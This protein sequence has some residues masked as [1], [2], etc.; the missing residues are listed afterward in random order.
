[1]S[2]TSVQLKFAGQTGKD[3]QNLG[4]RD[5]VQK[6]L[7]QTDNPRDGSALV[8]HTRPI[9]QY[10][11]FYSTGSE[12]DSFAFLRDREAEPV[13]DETST[14]WIVTCNFST[15]RDGG[16]NTEPIV[17][18]SP[19]D[20]A[21]A[22][23][24]EHHE[25]KEVCYFAYAKAVFAGSQFPGPP[26][27]GRDGVFAIVNT[28]GDFYDPPAEREI[29]RLILKITV[30]QADF[31]ALLAA[32][33]ANA[34]NSDRWYGFPPNT[35]LF[36]PPKAQFNA[37]KGFSYWKVSYEFHFN[38]RGWFKYYW[39]AG[40]REYIRAADAKNDPKLKAGYNHLKN[41]DGTFV[42]EPILL[43]GSGRRL[44]PLKGKLD[45]REMTPFMNRY[46]VQHSRPF[47]GLNII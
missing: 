44:V 42:T 4:K 20:L 35:I 29:A 16:P 26:D 12:Y 24:W 21:P 6:F 2:V 5:Y 22:I 31:D 34:T 32:D 11:D 28:A 15:I 18:S 9:P 43:N 40:V 8:L 30:N 47:G 38:F 13:S 37:E 25:E 3:H 1:M 7:V 19:I 36:K 14:Q 17:S 33:Y 39:D 27:A 41:D 45:L 23:E 10:G 46:R